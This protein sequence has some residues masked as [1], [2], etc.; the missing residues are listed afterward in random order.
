[1]LDSKY[2]WGAGAKQKPKWY[3]AESKKVSLEEK[4]QAWEEKQG[5]AHTLGMLALPKSQI[6]PADIYIKILFS[7]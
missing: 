7:Q 4:L 5:L 3:V 1:M 2:C 6:T